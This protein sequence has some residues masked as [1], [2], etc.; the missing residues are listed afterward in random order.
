MKL[1]STLQV[2]RALAALLVVAYHARNICVHFSGG[3]FSAPNRFGRAG[4]CFFFVLSGFV[5][6]WVHERDFGRPVRA[7][8]YF[9]R[10]ALRIY[11]IYWVVMLTLLPLWFL[12]PQFGNPHHR[13]LLPLVK[14]L[15][16]FPQSHYPHLMVAWT[17]TH[18]VLFYLA[19]AVFLFAR[20]AG[21][22][23]LVVW[24]LLILGMWGAGRGAAFPASYF[25][26]PLNLLF[27]LGM[28]SALAARRLEFLRG[29]GGL[30]VFLAGNLLFVFGL[31]PGGLVER[32]GQVPIFG[33]ASFLILA[34][35]TAVSLENFF[36]KR[37]ALLFLG[38]ASYS[39]Y[40]IH[41]PAM[42]LA[43][44]ALF[45]TGIWATLSRWQA[46]A[47]LILAGVCA[48]AVLHRFVERPLLAWLGRRSA[49]GH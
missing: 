40:L 6:L 19:F 3:D 42:S 15:L 23:L 8:A 2:Y 36:R 32:I 30:L 38:A 37:R 14:S 33:A 24:S 4:V 31:I 11:P 26:S 1:L 5:M 20:Q 46:F 43:G 39:V 25:W 7:G 10:R 22:V 12:F 18:E 17:L 16:L 47:A 48:G 13:E 9:R 21:V 41:L 34:G 29:G 27:P 44:K 28:L 49:S 35:S 45:A